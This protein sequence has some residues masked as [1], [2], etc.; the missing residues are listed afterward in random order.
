[1]IAT[2]TEENNPLMRVAI[3]LHNPGLSIE[4]GI[5]GAKRILRDSPFCG[6]VKGRTGGPGPP[7]KTKI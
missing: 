5:K 3:L 7:R 6:V 2:L 4:T 1:M